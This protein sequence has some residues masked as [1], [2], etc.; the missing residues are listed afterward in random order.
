MDDIL[1]SLTD[2]SLQSF[3]KSLSTQQK[4]KSK[5]VGQKL[6]APLARPLQER[7]ERQAAYE[8]TKAEVSKWQPIVKANREV[9]S[10]PIIF[11]I[12]RITYNSR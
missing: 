12:R 11:N 5:W 1:A 6:S 10:I 2:P 8:E 4:S 3:R 7:L 9:T